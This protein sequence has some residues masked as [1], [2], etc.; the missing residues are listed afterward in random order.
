MVHKRHNFDARSRCFPLYLRLVTEY[1]ILLWGL[2]SY[3]MAEAMYAISRIC[4]S[5]RNRNCRIPKRKKLLP[6]FTREIATSKSAGW[7]CHESPERYTGQKKILKLMSIPSQRQGYLC[8]WGNKATFISPQPHLSSSQVK[9]WRTV[10]YRTNTASMR[11]TIIEILHSNFTHRHS[12][13]T[14]QY[15]YR[16]RGYL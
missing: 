5:Q 13:Y 16:F 14:E 15:A 11:I 12:E 8:V 2:L 6:T 3:L 9:I 7:P 10:S 4:E 1:F